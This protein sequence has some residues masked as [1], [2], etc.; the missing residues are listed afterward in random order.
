MSIG[1]VSWCVISHATVPWPATMRG[2]SNGGTYTAPLSAANSW[3]A[4]EVSSNTAPVITCSTQR[5][6]MSWMRARFCRGVVA[7]R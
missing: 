4:A 6:P 5:P 2:W 1:S 7:G 3:A